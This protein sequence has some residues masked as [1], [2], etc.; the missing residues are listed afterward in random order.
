MSYYYWMIMYKR[1]IYTFKSY[2]F[3]ATRDKPE[4]VYAYQKQKEESLVIV[5]HHGQSFHIHYVAFS[6]QS[7]YF[8]PVNGLGSLSINTALF[9]VPD[10]RK[11]FKGAYS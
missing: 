10:T 6:Y 5:L 7:S 4:F 8:A 2:Q 11:A 1:S 9:F 3:A